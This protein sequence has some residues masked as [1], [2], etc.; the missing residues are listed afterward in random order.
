MNNLHPKPDAQF[1]DLAPHY[2]EL[3]DI[4]PYDFWAEYVMTLFHF[5]GHQ[6]RKVLDCACGTGNVSFELAKQ[7]L[8]VVGVDLSVEMIAQARAKAEGIY[9]DAPVR[10]FQGDLAE[11]DLGESFDSASCLYDSLNYI[12]EPARLQ[13]AFARIA[14]H[15]ETGGVFV[16]DLNSVFAFE[17]NLFT[18]TNR[19]PGKRLHYDWQAHFDRQTRLCTVQM[20]FERTQHDG[21]VQVF[22]E[23]HRERAY[24]RQ[25]IEAMLDA[26]GWELLHTFDAYTLNH[27][28]DRS[29][30]W[31]FVAQKAHDMTPTPVVASA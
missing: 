23:R 9:F 13:A 26:T 7:G 17:A 5:V 11:F 12:L 6:P 15:L 3:M 8:E 10:F 14:A 25:E 30:R 29:E 27:P 24:T 18:Q 31:F 22:H 21:T 1:G 28:H 20:R 2:D 19:N 16:F 4:V